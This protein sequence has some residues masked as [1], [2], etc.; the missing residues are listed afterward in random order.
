MPQVKQKL[1]E[2]GRINSFFTDLRSRIYKHNET[3][4]GL[5]VY[6]IVPNTMEQ[7]KGP[8]EL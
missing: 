2:Q 8:C 1:G 4:T 6:L 3:L 5:F 7:L